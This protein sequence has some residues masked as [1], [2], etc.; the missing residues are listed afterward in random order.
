MTESKLL[1]SN[2]LVSAAT[3]ALRSPWIFSMSGNRP[4]L[5]LPRLNGA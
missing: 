4:G 3:S 2:R 5:V 1:P